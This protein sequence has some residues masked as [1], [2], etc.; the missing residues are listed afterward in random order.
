MPC[1]L[2]LSKQTWTGTFP[3]M[4]TSVLSIHILGDGL[5]RDVR[6]RLGKAMQGANFGFLTPKRGRS[7]S[8]PSPPHQQHEQICQVTDS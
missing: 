8:Y 5:R 7:L 3:T 2:L 1:C 6:V 4:V